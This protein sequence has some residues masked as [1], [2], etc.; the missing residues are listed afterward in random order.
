[1]K[2]QHRVGLL[3]MLFG[4]SMLRSTWLEV[5]LLGVIILPAGIVLFLTEG[6]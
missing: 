2:L 6:D 5:I 1:M 3:L 4:L